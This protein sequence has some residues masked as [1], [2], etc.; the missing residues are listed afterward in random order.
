MQSTPPIAIAGTHPLVA[1]CLLYLLI[2]FVT[3]GNCIR[4]PG[5]RDGMSALVRSVVYG[6]LWPAYWLVLIGPVGTLHALSSAVRQVRMELL[7][8]YYSLAFL[9]VPA[10]QIYLGWDSC[11]SAAGCTAMV[12]KSFLT[13]IIWPVLAVAKVF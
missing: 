7:V 1:F 5:Q 8:I 11:G 2:A 12:V 6:A 3:F 13:G 4:A 10:Y 9:F